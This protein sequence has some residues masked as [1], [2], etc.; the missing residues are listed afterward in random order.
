MCH[1]LSLNQAESGRRTLASLACA[2]AL[3]LGVPMAA[4]AAD[5]PNLLTDNFQFA[6]GAYLV[7][8]EPTV[9]LNG[10][11]STGSDVNFD[12]VLGGGDSSRVRLDGSWRMTENNKHVLRLMAFSFSR[13]NSKVIDRDIQWGDYTF[14]ADGKVNA[15]F[16]FD[17]IELAYE[18][19]FLKRDNYEIGASFGVHYAGASAS[20][21]GEATVSDGEG[22]Q[23]V[24]GDVKKEGNVDLPL[25]VFGLRGLWRLPANFWIEAQA[26]YF[27]LSID[28]YDGNIQDY[29]VLLTWQPSKWVGIGLGYDLFKVNVDVNKDKFNGSLDWQY[30]GPMMF[31]SIAF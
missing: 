24:A 26:Q 17:V 16:S 30:D 25:P 14:A 23:T 31:Y 2:G 15:E 5:A 21:S 19:E 22:G 11:T 28:E 6:L 20:L 12:E 18:Y 10:E 1:R 4:T 13:D 29:R 8:T 27:G 9:R 3:L 7:Q